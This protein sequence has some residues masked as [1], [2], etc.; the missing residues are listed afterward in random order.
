MEKRLKI[1]W[2]LLN[3]KGVI[4]I[5]IDDNEQADL[6][7]LCDEI[8]GL[9]K[10]ASMFPWR[11]RTAKSD[12]SFGISQDYEWILCYANSDFIASVEGKERKY[13]E[14]EDFPNR[15]WRFHDLTKQTTAVERPNSFFTMVNP[16]T[17]EEYPAN[18]NRT[19]AVTEETFKKYYDKNRIIFVFDNVSDFNR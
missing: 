17:G 10:F 2:T 6:K 8:F 13:F 3:E 4:F 9:E 11:K 19:W 5:S 1:A 16:K 15:P 14:T 7:L 18:E 12:V